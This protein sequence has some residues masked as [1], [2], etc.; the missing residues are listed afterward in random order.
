MGNE[1]LGYE[2]FG[3]FDEL[4]KVLTCEEKMELI[5]QIVES[6]YC[7]VCEESDEEW[8]RQKNAQNN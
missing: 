1:E 7:N 6:I 4:L 8:R 3:S 5:G 2:E